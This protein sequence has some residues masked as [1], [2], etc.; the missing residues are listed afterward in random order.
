MLFANIIVVNRLASVLFFKQK[1]RVAT[2]QGRF[3]GRIFPVR[4]GKCWVMHP[5]LYGKIASW[6]IPRVFLRS[7]LLEFLDF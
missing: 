4:T 6:E 3:V 2:S 5:C 1:T 7:G